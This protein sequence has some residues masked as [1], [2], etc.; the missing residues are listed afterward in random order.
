MQHAPP[1]G[2]RWWSASSRCNWN[3]SACPPR[4]LCPCMCNEIS[5]RWSWQSHQ[6][7]EIPSTQTEIWFAKSECF[8]EICKYMSVVS[9][10]TWIILM[11]E[12]RKKIILLWSCIQ[13]HIY[14]MSCFGPK[15]QSIF[16]LFSCLSD[17]IY[18]HIHKNWQLKE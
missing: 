13:G 18:M 11:G 15:L 3:S 10:K 7:I 8:L 17:H 1:G 16:Y 9:Q 5:R 2:W 4:G 6:L 14:W 12:K